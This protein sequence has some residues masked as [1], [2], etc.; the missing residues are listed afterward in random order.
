M[1]SYIK[2]HIRYSIS[3]LLIFILSIVLITQLNASKQLQMIVIV[4]TSIFYVVWGI[5]HHILHHDISVKIVV[6]YTLIGSLGMVIML[7]FLK[8]GSL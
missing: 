6:E 8:G 3:L 2:N 1:E 4:F 7:F 5:S